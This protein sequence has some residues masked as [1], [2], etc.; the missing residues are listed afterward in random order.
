MNRNEILAVLE[1]FEEEGLEQVLIGAT[2]MGFHGIVR[3]TEDLDLFIRATSENVGKLER[4]FR[5]AY[6]D[7]PHLDEISATDLLV[8]YPA[9]TPPRLHR[10]ILLDSTRERQS[11]DQALKAPRRPAAAFERA[12]RSAT[13]L[14]R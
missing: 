12:W 14:Q 2:A 10:L 6:S 9:P 11:T 5:R 13:C 3:A 1:A 8:D 7:D 4:A